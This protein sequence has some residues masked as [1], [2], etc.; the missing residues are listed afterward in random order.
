MSQLAKTFNQFHDMEIE[1]LNEF[2][3]DVLGLSDGLYST[4]QIFE[5]EVAGRFKIKNA[6]QVTWALRKLS[7]LKAKRQ[8]TEELAKH[9][10]DRIEQWKQRQLKGVEQS[11]AFF[12][13]LLAE[14]MVERRG[15]NPKYKGE[16]TPYGRLTFRK[17]QPAWK[18][19]DEQAIVNFLDSHGYDHHVKHVSTIGNK[20]EFKKDFMI[21]RNVFVRWQYTAATDSGEQLLLDGKIIEFAASVE[22]EDGEEKIQAR[23]MSL[24][25][26]DITR[27]EHVMDCE[28]AELAEGIEFLAVAVVDDNNV[29]VPGVTIEDKPDAIDVKPE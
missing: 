21:V 18:Y 10:L 28:T 27:P 5:P 2:L 19:E 14:Y 26:P 29:V 7:A 22:P 15:V 3:V 6:D 25:C 16:T 23:G 12:E 11:T 9:E 1:E 20:T 8:D 13:M 24:I 4:E 17:Q